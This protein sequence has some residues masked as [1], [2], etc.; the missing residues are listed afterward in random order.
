MTRV[1]SMPV[2]LQIVLPQAVTL[3]GGAGAVGLEEVEFD[4]E[5]LRLAS[6]RRARS[7]DVEVGRGGGQT[8]GDDGAE[9]ARLKRERVKLWSGR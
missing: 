3:E 1:I 6:R 9:E 7:R 4:G 5:T 2:Q 8:G